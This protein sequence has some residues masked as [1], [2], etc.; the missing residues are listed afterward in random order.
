MHESLY[1]GHLALGLAFANIHF[2][3]FDMHTLIFG[4][5]QLTLYMFE[6]IFCWDTDLVKIFEFFFK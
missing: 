1:K 4:S 3:Q 6:D 5:L 2:L